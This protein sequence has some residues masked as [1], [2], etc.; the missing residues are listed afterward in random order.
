[1][2]L[3]YE[4]TKCSDYEL[5][6]KNPQHICYDS[7]TLELINEWNLVLEL[8]RENSIK[9]SVQDCLPYILKPHGPYYY[10]FS[11]P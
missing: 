1:L 10:Y 11:L 2:I 9:N 8:T 7:K 4:D 3:L 6:E 5:E